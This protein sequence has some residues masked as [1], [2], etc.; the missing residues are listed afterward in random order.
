MAINTKTDLC[1]MAISLMGDTTSTISS[2][3][4][5]TNDKE[6]V[7][8]LWYDI[9]RQYALKLLMPNFALERITV[10]QLAET[11]DFGYAFFYEYPNTA[12]KV[13]GVGEIADKANDYVIESTPLGVMAIAHDYDYTDGMP[14]R[15]IRDVTD[16]NRFSPET[17]LLI[18]RVLAANTCLA[19]TQDANK[20]AKLAAELPS[21]IST[22]SGLNAQE[23]RPIRISNSRFKAAKFNFNP[24][25]SDKR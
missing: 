16:I 8:S 21:H 23:N 15:I 6:R 22:A 24:N 4:T 3:D 25:F 7:F 1:N 2:I 11:P 9:S 13:L 10:S 18:A 19:I 12:L 20:A 5:P 14:I 17:K